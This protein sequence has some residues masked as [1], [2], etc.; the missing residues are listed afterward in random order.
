MKTNSMSH[1]SKNEALK[2]LKGS[3]IEI[4]E[5]KAEIIKE[6]L[7]HAHEHFP[8]VNDGEESATNNMYAVY[9]AWGSGKS[10][11][12]K[13]WM[14]DEEIK[15]RYVIIYF[16]AWKFEKD[17]NL[18][19]SLIEHFREKTTGGDEVFKKVIDAAFVF[20]SGWNASVE[21]PVGGSIGL[22]GKDMSEAYFKNIQENRTFYKSQK[23]FESQFKALE[24][25]IVNSKGNEGKEILVLL[26]I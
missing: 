21:F 15:K 22:R 4:L 25:I 14:N 13:H 19:L 6:F 24:Q 2:T 1:Y 3:K 9:G 8:P 16:E 10:S 7:L 26:M 12:F 5:E 23:E 17:Q 20:L 11:M 18:A